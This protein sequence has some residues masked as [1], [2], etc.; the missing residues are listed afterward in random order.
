[1]IYQLTGVGK[2]N[3]NEFYEIKR[4]EFWE[5]EGKTR[6]TVVGIHCGEVKEGGRGRGFPRQISIMTPVHVTFGVA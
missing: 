6:L 1:M 2:L 4:V 5:E 3:T